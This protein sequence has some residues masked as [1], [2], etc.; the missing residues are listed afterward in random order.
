[1]TENEIKEILENHQKWL[2]NDGGKKA[3][4]SGANLRGANLR[5]ANLRGANLR[6]A[7]LR[8][9]NLSGADLSGAD[10]SGADLSGANLRGA[11]LN[12]A[13]LRGANL[14]GANLN[15][16]NLRG[17]Y[18]NY[19]NLKDAYLNYTNLRYCIGN[20]KEIKSLQIGTYLI[21]YTKDIL[22]IGCQSY[23]LAEWKAFSDE[24]IKVMDDGAL[25]WWKLNK[26][27]IIELAE[28]EIKE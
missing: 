18:L 24:E 15:G 20:G 2:N 4:L 11:N 14:N 5:G 21:S 9:A 3:D 1:M 8:G 28:R 12:G 19:T 23:T 25:E 17:A 6:G 27:I 22:N 13:D 7:D 16:A 10:L 26:H